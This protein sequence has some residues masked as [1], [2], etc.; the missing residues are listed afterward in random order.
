MFWLTRDSDSADVDVWAEEPV[1]SKRTGIWSGKSRSHVHWKAVI[2]GD[3][4]E[5]FGLPEIPVGQAV[6]VRIPVMEVMK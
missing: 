4:D 1:R 3:L 5:V 6:R 2:A